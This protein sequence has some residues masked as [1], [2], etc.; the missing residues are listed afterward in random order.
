ML[1][2][3]VS[4]TCAFCLIAAPTHGQEKPPADGLTPGAYSALK[5]RLIGPAVTS[6]R[7]SSIAV[8]RKER[9]TW[10]VSAASGGIWKTTNA[11]TT[12]TPIFDGEGAYS[13]G[14][15]VL[16]PKNPHTVW[17]GTGENNS[18][19]SVGYGDGI[20]RSDDGGKNWKNMGLRSSE[21]IARIL[22]DPRDANVVFV[23]AQGPLWA[24][25]GDRGIF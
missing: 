19:R 2:R 16:D 1:A 22:F 18:Q 9:A 14:V 20:Y 10:Y 7:I 5:L 23:A 21:H 12:W 4:L 11:G 15:V 6:G 3:A 24:P 8:H 13:I 17:V 25:G